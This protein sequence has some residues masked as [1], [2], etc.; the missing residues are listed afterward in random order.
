MALVHRRSRRE[1]AGSDVGDA[2]ELQQ[3]LQGAVLAVRAVQQ[4]EDDVDL[5]ELLRARL[6]GSCTASPRCVGSPLSTTEAPDSSTWGSAPPVMASFSGSSAAST[7]R[8]SAR[9]ADRHDLVGVAVDRGEDAA[10]G[11]AGDGVLRAAAAEDDGHP[12]AADGSGD[13]VVG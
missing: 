9:D 13:L 5:T 11:H 12:R 1:D 10:G 4:R 2:G 8:P 7:H 6:P 3:P